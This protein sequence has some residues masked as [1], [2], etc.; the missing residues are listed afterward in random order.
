[1]TSNML[2]GLEKVG[3]AVKGSVDAAKMLNDAAD[4]LVAGGKEEIFTPSYF[5]YAEKPAV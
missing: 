5:I 1:M 2:T 4:W 3:L